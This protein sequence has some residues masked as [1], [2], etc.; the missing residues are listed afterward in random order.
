MTTCND[1][2][3]LQEPAFRHYGEP[4]Q[5]TDQSLLAYAVR[6]AGIGHAHRHQRF[7]HVMSLFG[8]GSTSAYELCERFNV[9]PTSY[10]GGEYEDD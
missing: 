2:H 6:N 7:S 4:G 9:N 5:R 8:L 1:K 3:I 10:V